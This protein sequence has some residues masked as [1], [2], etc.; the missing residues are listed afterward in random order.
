[1]TFGEKIISLTMHKYTESLTDIR[2]DG[3]VNCHTTDS[4]DARL[5]T[6]FLSLKWIIDNI[7]YSQDI[8]EWICDPKE[9]IQVC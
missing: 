6:L 4:V 9:M 2:S 5:L 1:M 8:R 3:Y 7:K